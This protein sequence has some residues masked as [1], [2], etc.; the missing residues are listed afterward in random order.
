MDSI[1]CRPLLCYNTELKHGRVEFRYCS[2]VC[3]FSS[4]TDINR[5]QKLQNGAVIIIANSAF[6]APVKPLLI[7]LGL[8]SISVLIENELKRI[9]FKSLNDLTPNYFRELHIR[10]SQQSSSV[11]RSTDWEMKLP[12]KIPIMGKKDILSELLNR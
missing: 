4:T 7:S 11:L 1:R 9:T 10:N 2:S 5:L 8:R 12:L 3:G 6:D